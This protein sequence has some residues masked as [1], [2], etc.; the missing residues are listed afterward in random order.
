MPNQWSPKD[1]LSSEQ[2]EK[3]RQFVIKQRVLSKSWEAI[4]L[5]V[6]QEFGYSI[7]RTQVAEDFR[8]A[9]KRRSDEEHQDLDAYRDTMLSQLDMVA[10]KVIE[11][12]LTGD[13]DAAEVLIKIQTRKSRLLGTDAPTRT[14]VEDTTP[15]G[16]L[17]PTQI[18]DRIQ[19]ISDR[20]RIAAGKTSE[21]N[22]GAIIDAEVVMHNQQ[23]EVYNN[24]SAEKTNDQVLSASLSDATA[25]ESQAELPRTDPQESPNS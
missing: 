12:A 14:Q 1:Q 23:S 25:T 21:A 22:S 20:L 9:M 8:I 17:T 13:L 2:V 15:R 19:A 4:A 16:R 7:T 5:E 24:I 6:R 3:R 18:Y 11:R 10:E